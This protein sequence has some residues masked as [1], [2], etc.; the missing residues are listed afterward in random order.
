MTAYRV[1]SEYT[2]KAN[3]HDPADEFARWLTP[4]QGPSVANAGGIRAQRVATGP[5]AGQLAAVYLMTAHVRTVAS[6]PWTDLVD[7]P[8]AR[9]EYWGDARS[10]ATR[11]F[12]G[13][14]IL[15][16]IYQLPRENRP[17]IL[18]F[19]RVRPG[20]LRFSGLCVLQ[21]LEQ[22]AYTD[23]NGA[24][25]P[26]L[27]ARLRIINAPEVSTEWIK[28]RVEHGPDADNSPD[29]PAAWR[30][31]FAEEPA[32]LTLPP[33]AVADGVDPDPVP[34]TPAAL[35]ETAS[36]LDWNTLF[37]NLLEHIVQLG[38]SF[39]PWQVAAYLTALRTKP[40]V[41][42]AGVSGTGK[43]KLPAIIAS[44][45]GMAPARRI[46]VRPDWTDSSEP[47]GYHDLS[48]CFRP[49]IVLRLMDAASND[50]HRFHTCVVDEMNL[51]PVENYFAEILS[52]MED[53]SRSSDGNYWSSPVLSAAT[54]D[55]HHTWSTVRIPPNF[56]IV[57]TV[58]VDETTHQFSRKVLD[59]A[60]TIEFSEIDL[61]AIPRQK[62][63][64]LPEHG[65]S[66]PTWPVSFWIAA[67]RRLSDVSDESGAF[68]EITDQVMT[69]LG[70]INTALV[71]A[72][73][74]VGYRVRDEIALFVYH[75]RVLLAG[76][77]TTAGTPV[78]PLD[79][80]LVMKILPRIVGSSQALRNMLKDLLAIARYGR[81]PDG[82]LP[83]LW[84]DDSGMQ[85]ADFV[86]EDILFPFFFD[87]VRLMARRL[88]TEG[89][90]SFWT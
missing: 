6:N 58:N 35:Q 73:M 40:F 11:A 80:A 52:A 67:N 85:S 81:I 46:A 32:P 60:F 9:I 89:Y 18:H 78:D 14:R 28:R 7:L 39:H 75:A 71:R 5:A 19:V 42:L 25:I 51:A 12:R 50:R 1:L 76:F 48:G 26:N 90:T 56:A 2:D 63:A 30:A 68:A 70:H 88:E 16:E 8:N 10:G 31:A 69:I 47:L 3:R 57:G 33:T 64:S 79:L 41:I 45:T 77:R 54:G 86:G 37:E 84:A 22:R 43:S 65:S 44:L 87:R 34:I 61:H 83:A 59:R 17:P 4:E 74:Q 21:Q 29:C 38:F 72:Q 13:N 15:E 66:T 55:E 20:K 49:G 27:L 53:V 23:S 24:S 36:S 82:Q 62:M